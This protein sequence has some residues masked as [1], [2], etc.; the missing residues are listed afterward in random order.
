ME[1]RTLT[2]VGELLQYNCPVCGSP[3]WVIQDL[4]ISQVHPSHHHMFF[5]F[6]LM[7]APAAYGSSQARVRIRATATA[8]AIG[9]ATPDL[10]HICDLCHSL[11]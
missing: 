2:P 6:L 11:Q 8:Y 1:L 7:A 3:T 4:I 10:S 9:I 5:F